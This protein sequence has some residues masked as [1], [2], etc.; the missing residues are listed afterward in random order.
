MPLMLKWS[1]LDSYMEL[2][3][4]LVFLFPSLA[5]LLLIIFRKVCLMIDILYLFMG[6][7]GLIIR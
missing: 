2:L 6:G 5:C 1:G 7:P 4:L 3:Y